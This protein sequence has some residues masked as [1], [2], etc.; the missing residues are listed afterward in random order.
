[1]SEEEN[2]ELRRQLNAATQASSR[3]ENDVAQRD[4]NLEQMKKLHEENFDRQGKLFQSQLAA[5]NQTRDIEVK[6]IQDKQREGHAIS[7]MSEEMKAAVGSLDSLKE[8]FSKQQLTVDTKRTVDLDSRERLLGQM[9]DTSKQ[10]MQRAEEEC[11]RLQG[12]LATMDASMRTLRYGLFLP[13]YPLT[14]FPFSSTIM[15]ALSCY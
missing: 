8:Q 12:L 7:Q 11:H 14:T 6:M 9:E 1:M 2:S 13:R 5:L 4:A 3:L 15:S 10:F